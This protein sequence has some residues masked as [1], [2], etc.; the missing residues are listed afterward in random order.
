ML[1]VA[2]K[3]LGFTVAKLESS[4]QW[5]EQVTPLLAIKQGDQT[6]VGSEIICVIT[7][8]ELGGGIYFTRAQT[9]PRAVARWEAEAHRRQSTTDSHHGSCLCLFYQDCLAL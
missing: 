3:T 8:N 9:Q 4:W 7:T 2:P 5:Q 1:P 6:L